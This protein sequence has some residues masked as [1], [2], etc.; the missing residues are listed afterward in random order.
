M[1]EECMGN[2]GKHASAPSSPSWS[3][4]PNETPAIPDEKTPDKKQNIQ[5]VE[6]QKKNNRNITI[7]NK[8]ALGKEAK[9][10]EIKEKEE[11]I[12]QHKDVPVEEQKKKD[13]DVIPAQAPAKQNIKKN[14]PV[15][16]DNER[17]E[18]V[19]A[20]M[21]TISRGKEICYSED[22]NEPLAEE[23]KTLNQDYI[24][25]ALFRV[26]LQDPEFIAKL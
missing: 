23:L 25:E 11:K 21:A 1:L 17:E 2:L 12:L 14:K 16:P 22:F 15:V 20:M 24:G 13:L 7:D 9:E 4:Y 3:F 5:P 19:V 8:E 18:A 6:E 10:R 26:L